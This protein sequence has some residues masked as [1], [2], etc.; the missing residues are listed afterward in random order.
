MQTGLYRTNQRLQAKTCCVLFTRQTELHPLPYMF[1]KIS[2]LLFAPAVKFLGLLPDRYPSWEL[3]YIGSPF[4]SFTQYFRIVCRK[5]TG[6]FQMVMR[7]LSGSLK[8]SLPSK[9]QEGSSYR[10]QIVV[11]ILVHVSQRWTGNRDNWGH[12]LNQ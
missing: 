5:Y 7:R 6:G 9:V 2:I 8:P 3:H 10:L 4:N 12:I 11:G 1:V